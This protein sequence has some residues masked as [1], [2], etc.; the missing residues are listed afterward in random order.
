MRVLYQFPLSHYCEKARWLLDHKELDYVAH[1]L[2]PGFH[3]AFAQ[4][5]TGQNKLPILKD[6]KRWIAESTQIALY[7]D[8]HYPEHSLL[9]RD[10]QLRELAIEIDKIADELGVHV[11]RWSLGHALTHGDEALEIMMGEQGYLRQFEKFSKPILKTL[12]TKSYELQEEKIAQ[13]KLRMDELVLV[14]NERLIDNFGRYLVGDRLGLADIA[15]CAMLA[16]IL[17]LSGTPWEREN[18]E[19]SSPE[20]RQYKDYLL[21]LPLGQY[22]QRIYETERNARVDWRG[23]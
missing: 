4:L 1:N 8:D 3:R 6:D 19:V 11:R 22:V 20:L 23:I 17:E 10:P 18:N 5:K 21:S 13:S 15:V 9:R 2:I 16:P 14:L 7:L 12:V